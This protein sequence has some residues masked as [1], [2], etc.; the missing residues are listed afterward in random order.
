MKSNIHGVTEVKTLVEAFYKKVESDK[1]LSTIFNTVIKTPELWEHHYQK[2][3]D[4]WMMNLFG[5]TNYSGQPMGIHL[6]VDMQMGYTVSENHFERWILLWKETIDNLYEGVVAN[7]AKLQADRLA[8]AFK[9]RL[10]EV[11]K[12]YR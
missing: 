12:K 6:W 4:F 2:L 3:T 5:E 10:L 11:Q 1:D 9:N 8:V 7:K